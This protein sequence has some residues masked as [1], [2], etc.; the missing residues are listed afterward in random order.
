MNYEKIDAYEKYCM[1]FWK[2]HKDD[3]ECMHYGRSIYV[4]VINQDEAYVTT[5]VVV[6][7]LHYIP[8]M[9]RLKRLFLCV[10]TVQQIRW[11]KKGIRDTK[12]AHIMSQP[13]NAEAW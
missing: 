2:E 1:L 8:I 6:T 3:T 7:Q 4:K 10:E 5:K 9:P 13:A 12:D 11:H